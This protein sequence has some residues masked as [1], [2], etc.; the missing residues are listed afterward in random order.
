MAKDIILFSSISL[1][2]KLLFTKHLSIMIKAGIPISE[3]I[4]S[5]SDQTKKKEFKGIL[6]LVLTDIQNGQPLAKS[7]GKFPKVFSQ[8]F[9]SLVEIGEQSGT[10]ETS[11]Q[12]LSQQLTKE[13][14]L[15]KKIQ[16]ALMYPGLIF[17]ATLIMGGFI[18][19]YILPQLV[20]FFAVF[21]QELPLTTRV[22]LFFANLMKSSG[23]LITGGS[24]LFI[25]FFL[26]FLKL[27]FIK[28]R[29]HALILKLPLFGKIISFSQISGFCRNLGILLQS[30]IPIVSSLDTTSQT[31][32]NLKF[33]TDIQI[34]SHELAKGKKIN[35]ILIE[36]KF[37]EFP[38]L[39]TKM[40]AVGE[41]TGKLE[42]TLL[43]LADFY[44]EEIDN[45]SKNL[46]T[47]LEP[48]LLL[49]IGLIVAFVALAIISPI[50]QLTGS[51]RR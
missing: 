18:S 13:Y 15:K 9:I 26:L 40:I 14:N 44:E 22:L 46:T 24:I 35:E 38:D 42:D 48:F 4:E 12:F 34:I 10:L 19:L 1:Q 7:L 16:G 32:S 23:L 45:I 47:I 8:F 29:W 2:D 41:Q 5:L 43:Y 27:P 33:K 21:D 50:Y 28:A 49:F 20:D 39:V 17:S 36:K 6:Q 30:G 3:A 51:I 25:I 37:S 31:L 11:L